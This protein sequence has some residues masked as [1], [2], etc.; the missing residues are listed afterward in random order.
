MFF[1]DTPY[2][3]EGDIG[4]VDLSPEKWFHL[5]HSEKYDYILVGLAEEKF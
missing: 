3:Q 1:P 2:R 4:M 5:V